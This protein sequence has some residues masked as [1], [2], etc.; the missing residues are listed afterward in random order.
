M[1]NKKKRNTLWNNNNKKTDDGEWASE[2]ASVWMNAM[3]EWNQW[4]KL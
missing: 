2:Q 4:V 1:K 3:N